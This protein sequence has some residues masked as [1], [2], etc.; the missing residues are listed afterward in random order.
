MVKEFNDEELR[1]DLEGDLKIYLYFFSS[2][3]GPC[4]TTK[5]K[6]EEF[7]KNINDI[8]YLIQSK[9]AKELQ[10]QLKVSGFPSIVVVEN[11]TFI[12]GGIGEKEI[13][14]IINGESNQ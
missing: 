10:Q 11:K 6:V 12:A 3:C 4:K 14:K 2:G 5:P 13:T 7:G 9:E 1:Q 8:V